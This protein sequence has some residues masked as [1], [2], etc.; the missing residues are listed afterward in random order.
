MP[1]L[2]PASCTRGLAVLQHCATVAHVPARADSICHRTFV[3]AQGTARDGPRNPSACTRRPVVQ[4]DL[5]RST[6]AASLGLKPGTVGEGGPVYGSVLTR[7][8]KGRTSFC[9]N[10][11]DIQVGGLQCSRL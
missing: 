11:L 5:P 2:P 6:A 9:L 1:S 7:T 8:S 3:S 10:R 4:A